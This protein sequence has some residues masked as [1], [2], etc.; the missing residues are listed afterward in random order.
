MTTRPC[1]TSMC[2]VALCG[3]VALSAGCQSEGGEGLL[4]ASGQDLGRAAPAPPPLG[5]AVSPRLRPV[6]RRIAALRPAARRGDAAVWPAVEPLLQEG[7]ALL[8]GHMPN[9][10][11]RPDVSR[12]EASRAAFGKALKE[13]AGAREAQDAPRLHSALIDL[14]GASRRWSDAQLGLAPESSL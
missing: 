9:D 10:L 2:R 12:Y 13:V 5:S 11:A 3:L 14:E 7:V 6:L 1:F 8:R 4:G